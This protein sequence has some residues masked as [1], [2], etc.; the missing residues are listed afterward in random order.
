[1]TTLTPPATQRPADVA[2]TSVAA[3]PLGDPSFAP[4][5]TPRTVAMRTFIPLQLWRF[6]VINLRMLRM[7]FLSH[8]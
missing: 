4:R 7:I 5:P 6:V 2:T 8:G 3:Q 1:M